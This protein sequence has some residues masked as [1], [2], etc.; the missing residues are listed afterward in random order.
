LTVG[1]SAMVSICA[2]AVI[3]QRHLFIESWT[4]L[5]LGNCQWSFQPR[6]TLL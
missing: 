6:C 1:W 5:L 2:G 3:E 4:A